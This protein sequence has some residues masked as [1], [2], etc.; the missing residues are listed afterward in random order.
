MTCGLPIGS[1]SQY[2][3]LFEE[4]IAGRKLVPEGRLHELSFEALEA[5][6]L[7]SLKAIYSAFG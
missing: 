2:D 5:D 4:Y 7:G 6:P 1:P 3:I